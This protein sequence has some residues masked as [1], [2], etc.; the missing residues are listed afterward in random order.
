MDENFFKDMSEHRRCDLAM[1]YLM[2]RGFGFDYREDKAPHT[3][4]I[5]PIFREHPEVRWMSD[6]DI[7][8]L[9]RLFNDFTP[10]RKVYDWL[11]PKGD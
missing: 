6:K 9:E 7:I 11:N 8:K 4:L 5:H 3:G 2:S 10:H 1:E